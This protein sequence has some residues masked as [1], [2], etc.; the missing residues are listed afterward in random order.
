MNR[1]G[2]NYN[3][4]NQVIKNTAIQNGNTLENSPQVVFVENLEADVLLNENYRTVKYQD[5]N[6][7]LTVMTIMQDN[8]I[9]GE[10]HP[11]SNQFVYIVRGRALASVGKSE[12]EIETKTQLSEGY[13]IIIPAGKWHEIH[14]IGDRE[15][16]LFTIYAPPEGEQ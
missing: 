8:M 13:C 11:D 1:Y 3:K 7:M 9:S 16:K 5:K 4:L 15:L 2:R 12:N 6:M 10:I 14:N